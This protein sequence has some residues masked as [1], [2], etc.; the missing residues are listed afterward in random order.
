MDMSDCARPTKATPEYVL[1]VLQNQFRVWI[2]MEWGEEPEL[3]LTFEATIEDVCLEY[4][5]LTDSKRLGCALDDVWQLGYS[6][7]QWQ[8]VLEPAREKTLRGVC[9]FIADRATAY[10]I[11][12]AEV[13]GRECLNAGAFFAVRS[14]LDDAGL[15]T[16][17]AAPSSSLDEYAR[18]E[19]VAFL[20]TISRLAPGA[21]EEMQIQ[22]RAYDRAILGM[23]MGFLGILLGWVL[24]LCGLTFGGYLLIASLLM[25]GVGYRMTS[26]AAAR[27]PDT[28]TFGK[29]ETFGDLAR[30]VADCHARG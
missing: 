9:E 29:I 21:L 7:Q 18:R 26:V 20:Q 11:L 1:A 17:D 8:E 22:N 15:E 24:V 28:V 4:D 2:R 23:G 30:R 12:P 27:T 6:E 13:L 16:R 19:P 3:E 14:H 5:L 10:E 25:W